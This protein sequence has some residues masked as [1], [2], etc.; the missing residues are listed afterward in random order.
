MKKDKEDMED[1]KK[2]EVTNIE[3][4]WDNQ[5]DLFDLANSPKFTSFVLEE[6]LKSIIAALENGEEK[7]ELFNVFNMSIILEIKKKHFKTVLDKVNQL[8]IL[9]EEYERCNQLKKLITKYKL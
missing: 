2:R 7:A 9:D 6:S 5:E 4:I 3:L 1:I 8:F